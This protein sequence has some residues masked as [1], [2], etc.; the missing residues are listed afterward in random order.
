YKYC[1]PQSKSKRGS[2]EAAVP[3]ALMDKKQAT[4]LLTNEPGLFE[5]DAVSAEIY[6]Y[7][8]D[9]HNQL[10]ARLLEHKASVQVVRET[11]LAPEEF[12]N[13]LGKPLRNLQHSA[14]LVGNLATTCYFKA[15]GKPWQR[16][17]VR[18]GV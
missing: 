16:A 3:A 15:G 7:E 10:K 4:R 11:T 8:L 9:F 1:R 18:P 5:E 17:K 2:S 12:P 14:T 6:L 13:A